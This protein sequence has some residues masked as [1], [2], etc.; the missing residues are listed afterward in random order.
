[1]HQNGALGVV[2]EERSGNTNFD[3]SLGIDAPPATA[4]SAPNTLTIASTRMLLIL[5]IRREEPETCTHIKGKLE[6]KKS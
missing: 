2:S 5:T 1:V 4:L 3:V 6:K